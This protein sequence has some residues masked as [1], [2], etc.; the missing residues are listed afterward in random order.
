MK[1]FL[2]IGLIVTLLFS[3]VGCS[4]DTFTP[5]STSTKFKLKK[6][7]EIT[8]HGPDPTGQSVEGITITLEQNKGTD[9]N[10]LTSLIGGKKLDTCETNSFGLCY[11]TFNFSQGDPTKV[12]PANDGSNYVALYSINPAVAKYL[13]LP[14]KDM[15]ELIS[16]IEKY[17]IQVI[18]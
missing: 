13:E 10:R 12:Y 8:L 15:K 5:N 4:S 17:K 14:E 7:T 18:Y 11:L 6:V 16:I 2:C 3:L 1:K 9:F